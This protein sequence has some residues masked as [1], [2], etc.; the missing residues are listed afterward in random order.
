MVSWI[1]EGVCESDCD[2]DALA[3]AI[4]KDISKNS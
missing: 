3:I 2:C 1:G 4:E